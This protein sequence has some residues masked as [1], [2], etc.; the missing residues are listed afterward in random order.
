ME[1]SWSIS[2]I[3]KRQKLIQENKTTNMKL[4]WS[5]VES[6]PVHNVIK[7]RSGNIKYYT[8]TIFGFFK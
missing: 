5:V 8:S 4:V 1:K 7:L 6:L 3:Q 2:K